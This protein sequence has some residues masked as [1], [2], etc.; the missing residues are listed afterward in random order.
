[1]ARYGALWRATAVAGRLDGGG[2]TPRVWP[3]IYVLSETPMHPQGVRRIVDVAGDRGTLLMLASEALQ[4]FRF[5]GK[6]RNQEL[7]IGQFVAKTSQQM[8]T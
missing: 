3:D 7:E 6:G 5:G 2:S 4:W 8:S 1:M